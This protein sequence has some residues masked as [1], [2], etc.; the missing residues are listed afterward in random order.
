M[1]TC[2]TTILA[3]YKEIR[4]VAYYCIIPHAVFI[5]K[6]SWGRLPTGNKK[7]VNKTF[8]VERLSLSI[9]GAIIGAV[10][11]YH[12]LLTVAMR[13]TS[14]HN[15]NSSGGGASAGGHERVRVKTRA[16]LFTFS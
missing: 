6:Q 1:A 5:I 9:V 3:V 14:A 16:L 2:T 7:A 11:N 8:Y 4:I 15:S 12:N 13:Q 10:K